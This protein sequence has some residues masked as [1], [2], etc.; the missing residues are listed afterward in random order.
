MADSSLAL[1]RRQFR[2]WRNTRRLQ[3]ELRSAEASFAAAGLTIPA[4]ADIRAVLSRRF[5]HVRPKPQ[6]TLNIIAIYH[7]YNWENDSLRPSLEKFGTVRH[8]DWF[9]EFNHQQEKA[10]HGRVKADMNRELVALVEQWHKETAADVIFTYLSGELVTPE[11]MARIQALGVPTVNLS[12]NDKENFIGKIKNGQATGM[13]DICRYFDLCWT[14]TED[15]RKKYCV[16][17]ATPLYLPEGANPEIHRPYEVEKTIDVSFIGQKYGNRAEV[18]DKLHRA[19]IPAEAF[20]RGWPNGPLSTEEMVQLYSKSRINLGF[21]GVSGHSHTYC[22]KGRDF[23]VAM[24]GGLYLTEYHQ[25]LETVY[26]LGQEIITYRNFSE[27][28]EKIRFLLANPQKA[29]EIRQNGFLRARKEHT[30]EMRLA[31]IFKLMG[32]TT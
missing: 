18:I 22:L 26:H 23:E 25:E 21:G 3:G 10:W 11:T 32:L 30:W 4:N 27:L 12:L 2:V 8:Y 24:S 20:G 31:R 19:G 16:A 17:S 1:Y 6:G 29:E 15:A 13:R 14:S 9:A 7:H 28:L 5:P